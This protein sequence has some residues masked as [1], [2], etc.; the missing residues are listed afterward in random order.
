MD[1]L[2][3]QL[4]RVHLT[5]ATHWSA[6]SEKS[7]VFPLNRYLTIIHPPF[8][9]KNRDQGNENG[10]KSGNKGRND[11]GKG[12]KQTKTTYKT[13]NG[14]FHAKVQLLEYDSELE[15][16]LGKLRIVVTSANL[17]EEDWNSVGQVVWFQDFPAAAAAS[18]S[19][20]LDFRQ[21][22]GRF[23]DALAPSA[24]YST[25]IL[26]KYDFSEVKIRLVLS[27]PGS[28]RT[29]VGL[30][31]ELAPIQY[32]HMRLRQLLHNFDWPELVNFHATLG[33]SFPSS[34]AAASSSEPLSP[35]P[36]IVQASSLG[37]LL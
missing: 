33:S 18:S 14:N 12:N 17:T 3:S 23:L 25:S 7:G 1:W 20:S 10:N 22:M 2:T 13:F 37:K 5:I 24:S 9:D 11:S 34:A 31:E 4:P 28:H 6:S 19:S 27:I 21:Q 16:P 30:T 32:G 15:F 8:E 26:E 29:V 35:P 36:V